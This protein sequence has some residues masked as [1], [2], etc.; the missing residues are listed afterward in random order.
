MPR[1]N[2]RVARKVP[3]K[4]KSKTLRNP[5][6]SRS[7]NVLRSGTPQSPGSKNSRF[8]LP[9]GSLPPAPLIRISGGA[10]RAEISSK[11]AWSSPGCSTLHG[12]N[13]AA[14]PRSVMA[15]SR[16]LA[17][18]AWMSRMATFTPRAARASA[19][20]PHSSP[21]APVMAAIRP[22]RSNKFVRS[23]SIIPA[24]RASLRTAPNGFRR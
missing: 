7:K 24:G 13:R 17:F 16:I 15:A 21:P 6:R 8:V 19:I 12:K 5:S 22:F 14:P 18:S 3:R 1:A 20:M 11:Q 23:G 10:H 9:R 2:V 4:F